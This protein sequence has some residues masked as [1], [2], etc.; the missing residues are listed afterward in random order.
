MLYIVAIKNPIE[1]VKLKA[2]GEA[3]FIIRKPQ[4]LDTVRGASEERT[5]MYMEI[6]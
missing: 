5:E 1:K 3:L 4:N 6:H 2:P